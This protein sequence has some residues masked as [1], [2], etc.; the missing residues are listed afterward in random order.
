[1]IKMRIYKTVFVAFLATVLFSITFANAETTNTN[2]IGSECEILEFYDVVG[3]HNSDL[4]KQELYE[5][6]IS[7]EIPDEQDNTEGHKYLDDLK[8]YP[9]D[10]GKCVF[11][12]VG[13][14]KLWNVLAITLKDSGEQ[15][16][17]LNVPQVI[18][19]GFELA[20]FSNEYFEECIEPYFECTGNIGDPDDLDFP[21]VCINDYTTIQSNGNRV[22]TVKPGETYIGTV[23]IYYVVE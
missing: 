18:W 6:M 11:H 14:S 21:E 2:D 1:M 9:T 16:L 5:F 13:Y 12:E 7:A 23:T 8:Y 20:D 19:D 22:V 17:Y 10:E 15:R 3:V 4:S